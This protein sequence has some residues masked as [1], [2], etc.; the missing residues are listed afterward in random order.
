MSKSLIIIFSLF[1]VFLTLPSYAVSGDGK[2]T[3]VVDVW[4]GNWKQSDKGSRSFRLGKDIAIKV[5]NLDGWIMREITANRMDM[6]NLFAPEQLNEVAEHLRT[7]DADPNPNP[8]SEGTKEA[9]S[10]ATLQLLDS[11]FPVIAGIEL[12]QASRR[13]YVPATYYKKDTVHIL[14]FTIDRTSK[15]YG[16][17]GGDAWDRLLKTSH[18]T[19]RSTVTL[20]YNGTDGKP[21]R[22][23]PTVF[24]GT[25]NRKTGVVTIELYQ[26]RAV[27][28]SAVV[29]LAILVLLWWL[30]PKSEILR[31][32]TQPL[33]PD[34]SYPWS[35]SRAQMAFWFMA[36]VAGF[37]FLWVVTGRLDTLNNSVLILIGIG[38]GTALGA[39]LVTNYARNDASEERA[40][41]AMEKYGSRRAIPWSVLKKE[42]LQREAEL[43]AALREFRTDPTVT[44]PSDNEQAEIR[45]EAQ[46]FKKGWAREIFFDWLSEGKVVSFHRFQM[47]AWTLAL[48]L[49]FVV[50]VI[51]NLELPEFDTTLLALTGISAGTYLGFK[52]PPAQPSSQ[53]QT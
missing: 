39:S 34:G 40:A 51:Q 15:G 16:T 3:L 27:V 26:L 36:V 49:V 31:D 35:L 29:V 4:E 20:G 30:A 14:K 10:S 42:A 24:D 1:S 22:Q 50:E 9:I 21:S 7:I 6:G 47:F 43:I 23:I 11:L 52:F 2:A 32:V 13:G 45:Q 5:V 48:G 19:I 33:R 12:P 18:R 37:L 44:L 28:L 25:K 53:Q 41:L 8:L 17:E 38:S 46:F